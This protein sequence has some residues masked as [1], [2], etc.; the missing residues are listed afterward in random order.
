M[1]FKCIDD[2]NLMLRCYPGIYA[3]ALYML[4]QCFLIHF[5]Q[6]FSGNH[7][8]FMFGDSQIAGNGKGSERMITRNH[9]NL[10]TCLVA[11]P[12]GIPHLL[13]RWID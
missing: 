9:N 7:L 6:L 4:C 1:L 3:I 13:A 12:D 8:L 5:I 2:T 10:N 11:Q